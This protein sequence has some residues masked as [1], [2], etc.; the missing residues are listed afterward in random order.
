MTFQ[1]VFIYLILVKGYIFFQNMGKEA[2]AYFMIIKNLK[3]LT[4]LGR[5]QGVLHCSCALD[6]FELIKLGD[7]FNDTS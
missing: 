1:G 2:G 6:F 7:I 3:D 4:E 5:I